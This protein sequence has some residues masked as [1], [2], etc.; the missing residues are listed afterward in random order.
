MKCS[1]AMQALKICS[2]LF[3]QAASDVTIALRATKSSVRTNDLA[4]SGL[5]TRIVPHLTKTSA[6]LHSSSRLVQPE[7]FQALDLLAPL[8]V[9]RRIL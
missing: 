3:K 7:L 2:M 4:E 5:A 8:G 6:D 1:G 9:W